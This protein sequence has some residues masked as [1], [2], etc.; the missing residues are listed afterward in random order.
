MTKEQAIADA[1]D[2][3]RISGVAIAVTYCPYMDE[4]DDSER[5]SYHPEAACGI[6]KYE[7]VIE[8]FYPPVVK[9]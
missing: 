7:E 6:F 2:V 5:Y 4:E 1:K 8:V 9:I 3:A